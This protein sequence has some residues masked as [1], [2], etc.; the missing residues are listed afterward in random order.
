MPTKMVRFCSGV[1]LMC[2]AVPTVAQRAPARRAR[3]SDLEAPSGAAR[4]ALARSQTRDTRI[5]A[6]LRQVSSTQLKADDLKLV[7]FGTR[8]TLSGGRPEGKGG[9]VAARAWIKAEFER[10]AQACGG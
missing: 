1:V 5:V 2:L 9:I 7:S 8:H 6:A 10:Y 4:A 3:L